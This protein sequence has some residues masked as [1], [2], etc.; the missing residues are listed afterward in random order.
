MNK[1]KLKVAQQPTLISDDIKDIHNIADSLV[2]A[3]RSL[4][5][6]TV[7]NLTSE[8]YKRC[9]SIENKISSVCNMLG[10]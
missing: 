8:I 6:I 2:D 4:N 7:G 1:T 9:I 5:P 3:C 10:K